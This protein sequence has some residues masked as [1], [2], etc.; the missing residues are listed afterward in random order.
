M[1]DYGL[2]LHQISTRL[3][4]YQYIPEPEALVYVRELL[5]EL[6]RQELVEKAVTSVNPTD[7]ELVTHY[8]SVEFDP[9]ELETIFRQRLHPSSTKLFKTFH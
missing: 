7:A 8:V 3:A 4:V 5:P 2:K 6:V 1:K 9:I